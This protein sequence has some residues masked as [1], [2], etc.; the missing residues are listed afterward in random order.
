[1]SLTKEE[2]CKELIKLEKEAREA[3]EIARAKFTNLAN[4]AVILR[5]QLNNNKDFNE[6]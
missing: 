1:M 2:F 5:A 6:D 3:A 4:T